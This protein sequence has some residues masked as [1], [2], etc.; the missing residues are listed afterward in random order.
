MGAPVLS[1]AL[2]QNGSGSGP[3]ADRCGDEEGRAGT[4]S[5]IS[6][7]SLTRTSPGRSVTM[8]SS[9]VFVDCSMARGLLSYKC[10]YFATERD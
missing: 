8:S 3:R 7:P 2:L 10:W 6:A 1:T 4:A 9:W 5:E